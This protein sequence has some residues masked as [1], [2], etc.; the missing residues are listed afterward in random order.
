MN[1]SS[2]MGGAPLDSAHLAFIGGGNMASAIVGG[3]IRQGMPAQRIDVVEPQAAQ[4][5]K[6]TAQW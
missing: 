3:L 1:T 5:D 6:L 2:T 4:R